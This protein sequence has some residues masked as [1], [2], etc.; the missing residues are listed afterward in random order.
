MLQSEITLH[1]LNA[2]IWMPLTFLGAD[3]SNRT[4]QPSGLRPMNK[5]DD[6]FIV[7]S[8][9]EIQLQLRLHDYYMGMI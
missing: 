7:M 8:V 4:L 3:N 6:N 2:E 5:A 9:P 1:I